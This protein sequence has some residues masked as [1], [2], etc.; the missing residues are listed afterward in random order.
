MVAFVAIPISDRQARNSSY[1]GSLHT[2][3]FLFVVTSL[4]TS[5]LTTAG[6]VTSDI[7]RVSEA[8]SIS[9][10]RLFSLASIVN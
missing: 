1:S 10:L 3:W 5:M 9:K 4:Q 7:N 2:N 6:K 8:I